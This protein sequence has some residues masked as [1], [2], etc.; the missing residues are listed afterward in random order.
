[1]RTSIRCGAAVVV[2]LLA[3]TPAVAQTFVDELAW[4]YAITPGP[5]PPAP[6]DDGTKY[7]L[8]GSTSQFTLDQIRNRMGPAD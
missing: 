6:A 1:M 2:L 3:S 4:A 7:S 5:A 8:T